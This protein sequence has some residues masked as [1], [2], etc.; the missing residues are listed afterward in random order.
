MGVVSRPSTPYQLCSAP[1]SPDSDG[2]SD[3]KNSLRYWLLCTHQLVLFGETRILEV[4]E[5]LFHSV[6]CCLWF[7]R[8]TT[9]F[10]GMLQG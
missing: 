1:S 6:R 2:I 9:V 8:K 3:A 5:I 10:W 7:H 4:L